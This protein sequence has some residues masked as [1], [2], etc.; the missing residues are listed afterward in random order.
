MF[1]R[2]R[3]TLFRPVVL[4]RGV[5]IGFVLFFVW[6]VARHW[7]PYF[8]F[9]RFL[10]CDSEVAAS[11]VPALRGTPVYVDFYPGSY[12]GFYYAEIATDPSIR[13]PELRLAVDDLGYRA[14]RILLSALAWLIGFG[15]PVAAVHVYAWINVV[16]WF[17]FAGL[18]WRVLPC[19]S[20]HA[21]IA[22]TGIMFA[23]GTLLSVRLALTDL[24]ALFLTAGALMQMD[25]G[26]HA[27]AAGWLGLAG[28]SRETALLGIV[29]LLPRSGET[30]RQR[31]RA[32]AWTLLP[33][34]PLLLWLA[35]LWRT[36]GASGAGL[37]N[38]AWPL[39][40]L[41]R[42]SADVFSAWPTPDRTL[43]VTSLLCL[44]ALLVQTLYLLLHP[45]RD[46]PWWRTE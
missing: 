46:N 22:W 14:R 18:L 20:W 44:A 4:G 19:N 26:R 23:T 37:G 30:P 9:T 34:L 16:A 15:D 5:R 3:Q 7:H 17:A 24:A 13:S 39:S 32:V 28:L 42:K 33:I 11:M 38:F 21:T 25:R 36:V 12:D 45:A 31:T 8:G 6:L 35:Y 27:A 41:V 10:Q 2:L 29:A 43:V 40:G 1:A